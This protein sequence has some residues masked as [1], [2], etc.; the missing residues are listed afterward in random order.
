MTERGLQVDL[1]HQ[2]GLD[3]TLR[4]FLIL[5]ESGITA[6]EE[7][8]ADFLLAEFEAVLLVLEQPEEP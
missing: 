2:L 5:V 6:G 3:T 7:S 1:A 8:R 4:D